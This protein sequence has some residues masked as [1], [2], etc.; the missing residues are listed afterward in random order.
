MIQKT[1][2]TF[3]LL[4][5]FS[6]NSKA[7]DFKA[8]AQK[9]STNSK[10]Q[11]LFGENAEGYRFI[12][13]KEAKSK[14]KIYLVFISEY[15][16]EDGQVDAA[17]YQVISTD[18]EGSKKAK[19]EFADVSMDGFEDMSIVKIPKEDRLSL[20]LGYITYMKEEFR[21][22]GKSFVEFARIML[23]KNNL[24]DAEKKFFQKVVD[25]EGK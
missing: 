3:F 6:I 13:A 25:S 5:L 10:N 15:K 21:Q 9:V 8:L 14:K 23:K 11:E 16:N 1:I 12:F 18:P 22:K 7:M 20:E 19:L 17:E 2:L 4:I 24:G